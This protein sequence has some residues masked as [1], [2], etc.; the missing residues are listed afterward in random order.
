MPDVPVEQ[1]ELSEPIVH[2]SWEPSGDRFAVVHGES[3]TTTISLYSMA[4]V[5]ESN[6]KNTATAA[7][8]GKIP[9]KELTFLY[10]LSN[11]QCNDILWSPA[12][13][14]AALAY[15]ASDSCLFELYDIE[16]NQSYNQ[17]KHE[18]GNRLVWD[19][20]GRILASCTI[21]T[22]RHVTR[23]V[24]DD[25]YNLYTF[26]GQIISQVKKDKLYQ[27]AWRPRPK[28]LLSPEEKKKI[29]KNL[30]K[31]ER[32]FA[33]ED[34]SRKKELDTAILMERRTLATSFLSFTRQRKAQYSAYKSIRVMLR[35]GYD[36]DD[37]THFQVSVRFE[38]KVLSTE[39]ETV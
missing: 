21:S 38:E 2:V 29:I 9:K 16:N 26:Q 37:D 31:Y 32:A 22:L 23:A 36:S 8:A 28:D 33:L 13:N 20:S 1:V 7:K 17:R 19:P 24:S 10:S 12:G 14:V 39:K 15:F 18:R 11:K 4:G 34:Q 5:A 25:G 3:R 30:K 6:N 27:F 35:D